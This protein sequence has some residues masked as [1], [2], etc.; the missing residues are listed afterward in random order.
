MTPPTPPPADTWAVDERSLKLFVDALK[1]PPAERAWYELRRE[2]ERIA[3]VPGFDRLITLEANAIKEL[4]HQIDVAQRVLRDIDMRHLAL[5]LKGSS[6][7]VRRRVP[8]NMSGRAARGARVPPSM[9]ATVPSAQRMTI[10]AMPPI[11]L[12]KGSTTPITNAAATAASTALPPS[13]SISTPASAARWCSAVTIASRARA[14]VFEWCHSL[15][16]SDIARAGYA[17]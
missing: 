12:V 15:R 17:R 2:A 13:R 10:P 16:A 1:E 4:P 3:L 9:A 14:S 8:K 5:A 6:E 11:P 7:E